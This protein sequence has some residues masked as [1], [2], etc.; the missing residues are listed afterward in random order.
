MNV[1]L[2]K[3]LD[4]AIFLIQGRLPDSDTK[5]MSLVNG[6]LSVFEGETFGFAYIAFR[7]AVKVLVQREIVV[8]VIIIVVVFV[9]TLTVFLDRARASASSFLCMC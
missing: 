3:L 7:V 6:L 9:A 5:G 4:G 2:S 8:V 1:L